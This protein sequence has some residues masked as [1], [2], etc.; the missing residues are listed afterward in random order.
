MSK[1]GKREVLEKEGGNTKCF[2]AKNPKLPKTYDSKNQT[3]P[4][5]KT[6][7][8]RRGRKEQ[9]EKTNQTFLKPISVA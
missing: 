8:D 1:N 3:K 2:S 4:C 6:K 7:K 9:L 5:D